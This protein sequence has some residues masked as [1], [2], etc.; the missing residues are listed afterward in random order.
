VSAIKMIVSSLTTGIQS[1]FGNLYANNE[2]QLLNKY[3]NQ[4]EWIVHTG[5]IYLYGMTAVL[6][7]PSVMIYTAGVENI[8]Y[9]APTFSLLLVLA[10]ASFSLRSPYQ[11]I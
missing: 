4:I 11:S 1:F 5:V 8:S 7:G 2:I 9:E 3:F 6:I 10:G